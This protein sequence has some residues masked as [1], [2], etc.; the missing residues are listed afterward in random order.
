[1]HIAKDNVL[2]VLSTGIYQILLC[3]FLD[4]KLHYSNV[5]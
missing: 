5:F 1:M 2:I 4:T 3:I